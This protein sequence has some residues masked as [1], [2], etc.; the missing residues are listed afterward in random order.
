MVKEDFQKDK[1][2]AHNPYNNKKRLWYIRFNNIGF[3]QDVIASEYIDDDENYSDY[4]GHFGNDY[5]EFW[6]ISIQEIAHLLPPTHS[7][8]LNLNKI[9]ELW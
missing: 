9:Y 8:L 4:S 2:Y 6:K 5:K 3:D 7:D 1:W